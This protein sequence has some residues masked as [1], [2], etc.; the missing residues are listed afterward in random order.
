ML[1]A[2]WCGLSLADLHQLAGADEESFRRRSLLPLL[3]ERADRLSDDG[4]ARLA[5][6][7]AVLERAAE[8]SGRVPFPEL[9]ESTWRA[10][11]GGTFLNPAARRNAEQFFVLLDAVHEQQGQDAIAA[12]ESRMERLFAAPNLLEDAVELTTIHG[13]KGLEWDV[14]LVPELDRR[15]PPTRGRLL[16]WEEIAPVDEGTAGVVFAPIKDATEGE[17][18]VNAWLRG[19]RTRR[20]AAER[21]RLFYVA[22]TRAREALHLF[23]CR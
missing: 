7:R 8:Q 15:A 11:G 21:K 3:R 1:R 12:L 18:A 19:M 17:W 6:V 5:P 9:V 16:E 4:R 13:A 2:P 23:D 22:C 14:V 10:L 20:L